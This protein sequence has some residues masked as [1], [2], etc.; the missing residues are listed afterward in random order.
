[1]IT[2]GRTREH[3]RATRRSSYS[4]FIEE[5]PGDL[6]L[7]TPMIMPELLEAYLAAH[8]HGLS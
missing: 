2:S 8:P 7:H 6:V 3:A 5:E 4:P 1:M